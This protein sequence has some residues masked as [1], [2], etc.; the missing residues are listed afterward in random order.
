MT[1]TLWAALGALATVTMATLGSMASQ[2]MQ[3]R[4]GHLPHAILRLAARRLD[5]NQHITVHQDEWLPELTY[6]LKRA[7]AR[8]ITRLITGTRFALGIL[9]SADHIACRLQRMPSFDQQ[10]QQEI[11]PSEQIAPYT[12]HGTFIAGI[13]RQMNPAAEVIRVSIMDTGWTDI[14]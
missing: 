9:A 5:S 14:P 10:T 6:I 4:L 13:V 12:G 3:D 8:P 2:E 11:L 1:G 7:E